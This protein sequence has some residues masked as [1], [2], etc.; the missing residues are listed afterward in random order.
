[1]DFSTA[2]TAWFN[3]PRIHRSGRLKSLGV[4]IRDSWSGSKSS[5]FIKAKREAFQILL[6]KWRYP[7]VLDSESFKSLPGIVKAARVKRR[8]S[9]P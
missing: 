5:K 9:A 6:T 3:L 1:M 4:E 8:A 7:S 2:R